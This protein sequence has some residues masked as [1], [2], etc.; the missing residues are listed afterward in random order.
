MNVIHLEDKINLEKLYILKNICGFLFTWKKKKKKKKEAGCRLKL[1]RS[2]SR[3]IKISGS[4][5]VRRRREIIRA[6]NSVAM[7]FE[8]INDDS[9]IQLVIS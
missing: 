2:V 9:P 5:V 7:R 6:S 3:L 8:L 1:T 4:C